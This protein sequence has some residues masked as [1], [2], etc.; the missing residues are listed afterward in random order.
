ML[1]PALMILVAAYNL[2]H[3]NA[4]WLKQRDNDN[5]FFPGS[6]M[7]DANKFGTDDIPEEC[8][9]KTYCTIKPPSYPEE[10][11][12]KMFKGV[13][14]LAQPTLVLESM[15]TNRQGDPDERDDCESEVK[16]EP[17]YNVRSKRDGEWRVVVQGPG[18]DYVQRVRLETCT[19]P[20]GPC[21]NVFPPTSD[22]KVFCKQKYN[23]WKVLV[24]KGDNETEKIEVDLPV[25]CSCQYKSAPIETRFGIP[26][27]M[28]P[29]VKP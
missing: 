25:C 3:T 24:A 8:R 15:L 9:D 28:T 10:H 5:I 21:F 13:K 12:N 23:K 14:T 16:Y 20:D 18:E 29:A 7:G 27:A 17:L 11:F 4:A 1:S 22:I 2:H 19:N 6:I 26:Q